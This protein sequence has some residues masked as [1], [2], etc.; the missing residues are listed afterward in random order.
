M[1]RESLFLFHHKLYLYA[2]ILCNIRYIGLRRKF[3]VRDLVNL[4]VRV[5]YRTSTFRSISQVAKKVVA[6]RLQFNRLWND[7]KL[8]VTESLFS[9]NEE[10]I[11]V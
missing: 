1:K 10:D 5:L 8:I 11:V 3:W 2:H 4:A 9:E 6:H 7:L